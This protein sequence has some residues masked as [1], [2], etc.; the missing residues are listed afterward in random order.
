L[1]SRIS[2]G[3]ALAARKRR[4]L[5]SDAWWRRLQGASDDELW[6]LLQALREARL[7]FPESVLAKPDQPLWKIMVARFH[8]TVGLN[9]PPEPE[10]RPPRQQIESQLLAEEPWTRRQIERVR[11]FYVCA[12]LGRGLRREDDGA[13]EFAARALKGS[14][15]EG[16]LHMMKKSYDQMQKDLPV[17]QQRPRTWR[18]RPVG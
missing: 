8:L 15:A 7:L 2:R 5:A 18:P 12:A 13:Y 10:Q 17:N 14:P 1:I 16:S 4:V 11:W 6:A 3:V 9:R